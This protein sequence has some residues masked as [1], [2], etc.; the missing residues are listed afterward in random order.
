MPRLEAEAR[1]HMQGGKL[2][3]CLS[4]VFCGLCL[5]GKGSMRARREGPISLML[6]Q[7]SQ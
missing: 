5:D 7:H 3:F 2:R 1:L 6:K 4:V